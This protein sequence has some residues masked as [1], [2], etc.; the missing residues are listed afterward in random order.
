[1]SRNKT[2]DQKE[3]KLRDALRPLADA[4]LS[5]E[6][7]R[8]LVW[9][10]VAS[11]RQGDNSIDHR[12][13]S[14]LHDLFPTTP[15]DIQRDVTS[16]RDHVYKALLAKMDKRDHDSLVWIDVE[17]KAVADAATYWAGRYGYGDKTVTVEDVERIEALAVGHIDYASKLA[18][19]IAEFVVAPDEGNPL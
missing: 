11:M 19:Y 16:C 6:Q 10:S 15:A 4:G 12:L 2:H 14:I 9:T 17:R 5:R 18:L 13:D 7:A 8:T 1:M 3:A